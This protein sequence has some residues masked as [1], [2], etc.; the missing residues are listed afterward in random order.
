MTSTNGK[1]SEPT[2][3]EESLINFPCDFTIKVMG[4]VDTPFEKDVTSIVKK[5]FN[6]IKA[7]HIEKRLSKE[8]NY[9]SLSITVHAQNKAELDALYLELSQNQ[10]VLMTL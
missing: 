10:Y 8:K 5:H 3:K 7:E 4:K 1:S 6:D 9:L 2:S